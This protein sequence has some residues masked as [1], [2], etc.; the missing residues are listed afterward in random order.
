MALGV[1][2]HGTHLVIHRVL[3]F[4]HH[5]C[6]RNRA[7]QD[8]QFLQTSADGRFP[9][10]AVVHLQTCVHRV[11]QVPRVA[12]VIVEILHFVCLTVVVS[13]SAVIH[14]HPY[15]SQC[16][17]K[18]RA[19]TGVFR[20]K[21]ALVEEF[22]VARIGIQA[23]GAIARVREPYQPVTVDKQSGNLLSEV[24]HRLRLLT[25]GKFHDFSRLGA[26]EDIVSVR[27]QAGDVLIQE[28]AVLFQRQVRRVDAMYALVS[29][30]P[31]VVVV[32]FHHA[33]HRHVPRH[34][35]LLLQSVAVQAQLIESR[36]TERHQH[37]AHTRHVGHEEIVHDESVVSADAC[38]RVFYAVRLAVQHEYAAVVHLQPH[39]LHLVDGHAVNTVV[40]PLHTAGDTRAVVVEVVSVESRHTVPRGYPHESVVIVMEG[41]NGVAGQAVVGRVVG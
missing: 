38:Q 20:H 31:Q 16:F 11:R 35:L 26:C 21:H 18:F 15:Q 12:G 32:A 34:D 6:P 8:F 14:A 30:Y 40:Q 24:F 28:V 4:R 36:L 17:G 10:H 5:Q 22:R 27:G 13:V 19:A 33:F 39:V 37:V 9:H 41:R 25:V 3:R 29:T 2:A 23:V 7:L 1:V